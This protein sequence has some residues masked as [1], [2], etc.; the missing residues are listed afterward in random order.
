MYN[1]NILNI[2]FYNLVFYFFIYSCLG[3]CVEVLYA[4]KNQ[5]KFVNRGFLKGPLCPIYGTCILSIVLL[6]NNYKGNILSLFIIAALLTSTI[7]YFT[8]YLLEKLFK[9]KYWDYTDDPFNLH[10]RICLHFSIM[11]GIVSVLV[12][13]IIHPLFEALIS[14]IPINIGIIIISFIL[15][16]ILL[17][18][19]STIAALINSKKLKLQLNGM[20]L[21]T[22][23]IN[24][25][26]NSEHYSLLEEKIDKLKE[27]LLKF[28]L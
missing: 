17:D 8:G 3:W 6:L 28:K 1:F 27:V 21:T 12:V 4:Y 7:E 14:Y 5:K 23:Y 24:L 18:F 16:I 2:S 15:A 25:Y 22:K 10:G 13:K 19:C 9:T 20:F 11:W 26:R